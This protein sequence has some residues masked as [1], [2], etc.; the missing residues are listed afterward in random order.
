MLHSPPPGANGPVGRVI[1]RRK[2]MVGAMR[3]PCSPSG[4]DVNSQAAVRQG[5]DVGLARTTAVAAC[6]L[7]AGLVPAIPAHAAPPA[8]F[9]DLLVV[10]A[11]LTEPSGFEIAPDGRIFVLERA[12]TVRIVKDG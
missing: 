9:Q 10:G 1:R 2:S 6:A 12:G 4:S 8:G 5:D 7:I 11:G 3:R